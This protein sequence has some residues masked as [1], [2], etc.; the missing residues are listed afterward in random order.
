MKMI[1]CPCCGFFTISMDETQDIIIDFCEVC[2]WQYDMAGILTPDRSV[3]PNRMSLNEAREN[4][5]LYR[6]SERK[7]IGTK[8]VREPL[9]EELPENNL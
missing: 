5:K 8:W 7:L 4:Y 9:E 2:G 3:G 1:Q 6:A